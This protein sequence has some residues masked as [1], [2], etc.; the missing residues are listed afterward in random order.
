MRHSSR[1]LDDQ[2]GT[3]GRAIVSN[4]ERASPLPGELPEEAFPPPG[5]EIFGGQMHI[6]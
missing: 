5:I 4:G 1:P 6:R 2:S 3:D